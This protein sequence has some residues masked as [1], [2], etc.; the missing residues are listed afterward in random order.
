MDKPRQPSPDKTSPLIPISAF[1]ILGIIA[2]SYNWFTNRLS[3]A[4]L[5]VSLLVLILGIKR[6]W[7]HNLAPA[8]IAFFLIGAVLAS[9]QVNPYFPKNHIKMLAEHYN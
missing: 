8:Y 3:L 7:R 9:Q 2:A 5:I 4:F 1:F 6:K